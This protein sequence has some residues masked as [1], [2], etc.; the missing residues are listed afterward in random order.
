[1]KKVVV[2][3]GN[4]DKSAAVLDELEKTLPDGYR[5]LK[6]LEKEIEKIQK[7]IDTFEKAL[8]SAEKIQKEAEL[9]FQND[10]KQKEILGEQEKELR[11]KSEEQIKLL[12]EK[13]AR[14]GFESL[15]QCD[16]YR[17][18][19]N[20]LAGYEKSLSAYDR[21]VHA[22]N[23]KSKMKRRLLKIRPSRI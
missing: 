5:D 15:T 20:N 16:G 11:E 21:A 19:Q 7:E 9:L 17:K 22:E 18:E 2:A 3:K 10:S 13:V 14:A 12:R 4:L 6:I 23:E 1:M 8:A